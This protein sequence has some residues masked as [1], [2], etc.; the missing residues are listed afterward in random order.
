M[1][2]E[3]PVRVGSHKYPELIYPA[4][5]TAPLATDHSEE[6]PVHPM[7]YWRVIVTRRWTI[8]AIVATLVTVTL[9]YTLKQ[10]PIYRATANIQI[11]KENPNILSFK[12]V[13]QIET[14]T[15]DMLRTQFEVLKSRR[16]AR[17]VIE[18]L[19]LDANE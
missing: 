14:A 17:S 7:D 15:D 18:D 12:D 2:E 10:T 1:P 9:I 4:Q 8:L 3:K 16:L 13:Y 6:E 5:I 19:K 11:D